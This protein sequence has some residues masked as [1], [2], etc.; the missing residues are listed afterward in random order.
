MKEK[1]TKSKRNISELGLRSKRYVLFVGSLTKQEGVHYLIEAF[2]QLED[3]AKTPNNFKLAIVANGK[4]K[5][6]KDYVKYLCTI[7]EKR[8]N[9]IFFCVRK[10]S[11]IKQLFSSAYLYVQPSESDLGSSA[12]TEAMLHGIAPLVSET[13]GNLKIV[14][15]DGFTFLPKS[16]LSLRDRLAY[17]LSRNE[18]VK[19][20]GQ[21]AEKLAAKR[22]SKELTTSKQKKDNKKITSEKNIWN[23]KNL[24][25]KSL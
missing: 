4:D 10:K 12:L 1:S 13:K 7:S 3:T 25:K 9:I 15:K 6:D 23:W 5:D 21:R 17:L 8:D 16:V 11:T 22:S 14:G 20:M 18:E 2:K 24:L 19:L